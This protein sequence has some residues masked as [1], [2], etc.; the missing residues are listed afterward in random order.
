KFKYCLF[1]NDVDP[2]TKTSNNP[3]IM[4]ADY[5]ELDLTKPPFSLPAAK[6]LTYPSEW[7]LKQVLLITRP[8]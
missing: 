3:D 2:A 8:N 6:V 4:R 7:K 1:I 5:R